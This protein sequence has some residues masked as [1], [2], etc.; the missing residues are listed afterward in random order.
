MDF[1]AITKIVVHWIFVLF[2]FERKRENVI[3]GAG[4]VGVQRVSG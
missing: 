4:R 2:C 1:I 3:S